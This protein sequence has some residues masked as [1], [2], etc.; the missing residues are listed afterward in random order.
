MF[1]M[2]AA[3]WAATLAAPAHDKCWYH[4]RRHQACEGDGC[5]MWYRAAPRRWKIL[6]Q[7]RS[8]HLLKRIGRNLSSFIDEYL[9]SIEQVLQS[10]EGTIERTGY[11]VYPVLYALS[12]IGSARPYEEGP[13]SY[14]RF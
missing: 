14:F 9:S 13:F 7:R 1:G 10:K 5:P 3:T 2:W 8:R 4:A 6:I 11:G 12:I